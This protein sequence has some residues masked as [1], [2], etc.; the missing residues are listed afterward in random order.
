M[1]ELIFFMPPRQ[2]DRGNHPEIRRLAGNEL[3]L[4]NAH[5]RLC[6]QAAL[7]PEKW[8]DIAK[9]GIQYYGCF[10]NGEMVGRAAI[11]KYSADQWEVADV[12]VA[13]GYRN[14]GIAKKLCRAVMADIFQEGKIATIRTEEDNF[15][16]LWVID[17]LGFQ[18]LIET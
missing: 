16:M 17:E 4:F 11:E 3:A 15:A 9:T 8:K 7:S 1:A 2:I 18:K 12:R 10:V 5:L 6:G 13:K 14:Q